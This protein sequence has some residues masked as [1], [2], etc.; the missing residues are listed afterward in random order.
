MTS[1]LLCDG[2][3][4]KV[5]SFSFGAPASVSAI[6]ETIFETKKIKDKNK[7]YSLNM[8]REK[9]RLYLKECSSFQ[10]L[11]QVRSLTVQ[12]KNYI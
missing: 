4:L 11:R 1:S 2:S 10:P 5:G 7:V 12:L 3:L 9:K 8:E 6:S